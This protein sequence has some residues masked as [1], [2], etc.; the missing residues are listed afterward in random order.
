MNRPD[1]FASATPRKPAGSFGAPARPGPATRS[2]AAALVLLLAAMPP[3]AAI[4]DHGPEVRASVLRSPSETMVI[5]SLYMG[6]NIELDLDLEDGFELEK[7][8]DDFEADFET[9]VQV[10][11]T[12]QP[13]PHF[14]AHT[15]LRLSH[16]E[17][18][19]SPDGTSSDTDLSVRETYLGFFDVVPGLSII[20]GRQDMED[21][22]EWIWDASLDGLRLIWRDG[23]FLVQAAA[24]RQ[25]FVDTTIIGD[26]GSDDEPDSYFLRGDW[27]ID[28]DNE[29]GLYLL[30]RDGR[31]E[32][33]EDLFYVGAACDGEIVDDLYYWCE[34]ALVFGS[35]EGRDVA[36]AAIDF[37]AT[38]VFDHDLEPSITAGFAF[39]TGDNGHGDDGAFRQT[40]LQDNNSRFNGVTSFKYLG[41]VFEPELSNMGIATLGVGIRPLPR[42]SLDLVYHKYFQHKKSDEIRD[43]NIKA[44]PTGKSR[45]LGHEIDLVLG[46]REIDWMF[47]E[48]TAGVFLPGDAFTEDGTAYGGSLKV[49][50]DF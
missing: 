35:S 39:G 50:I 43:T 24:L 9:V 19:D 17:W 46:I 45:D 12:F 47:I 29:V 2:A 32:M 10:S 36:G 37:G 34:G 11:A 48:A 30:Y 7:G 23:H 8:V 16:D 21:R 1:G 27:A 44:D 3:A 38:Y 5:E 41:E 49:T 33:D 40:G 4:A 26:K 28:D 6:G 22:R 25:N 18:L 31:D 42:T 14:R 13:S 15:E 20:V